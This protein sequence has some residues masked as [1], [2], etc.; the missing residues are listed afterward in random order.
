MY[1]HRSR[2]AVNRVGFGKECRK[3]ARKM[4][5]F[6]NIFTRKSFSEGETKLIRLLERKAQDFY[7]LTF[8]RD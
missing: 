7:D 2:R 3:P 1:S 6:L 4:S 5:D 8:I